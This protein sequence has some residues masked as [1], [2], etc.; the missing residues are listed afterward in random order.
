MRLVTTMQLIFSLYI[1]TLIIAGYLHK[2]GSQPLH[3]LMSTL[4]KKYGEIFSLQLGS[5]FTIILNS[6]DAIHEAL[7]KKAKVFAGRPDLASF[8]T[9]MHGATGISMC[10]YT[11]QYKKNRQMVV[12]AM[13]SLYTD[14]DR[15]DNLLKHEARKMIQLFEIKATSKEIFDPGHAFDK[16][17]PSIMVHVM[18]G[19]NSPYDDPDVVDLV[20]VNKRW[21]QS[22]GGGSNLADF[23][24]FLALFPNERLNAIQESCMMFYKFAFK[25]MEE[26]ETDKCEGIYGTIDRLYREQALNSG[27]GNEG[28]NQKD[29]FEIGRIVNDMLGGGFDTL[30]GTLSWAMLHLSQ[31]P[32]VVSKCRKEIEDVVGRE[33]IVGLEHVKEMPYSMAVV[34]EI[35]RVASVAPLGLPHKTSEE[36]KIGDLIIPQDSM[37]MANLWSINNQPDLWKNAKEFCPDNFLQEDG[38]LSLRSTR[39]LASFSFGVRRCP[40]EKFTKLQLFILLT[41]FL[42]NFDFDVAKPPQDMEPVGGITIQPKPYQIQ[43]TQHLQ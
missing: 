19:K 24:K 30:P 42:R 2:L 7:V 35:F 32:E 16:I 4:S 15:F 27:R 21:F 37:V 22:A 31:S 1:I 20:D 10:D 38:S 28:L 5:R 23:L 8:T 14:K 9:T 29:M 34:Y 40:G 43:I 33:D 3:I 25:K 13:H 12:K 39:N 36:V 11:E 18:F 26:F 6:K 17:V 41:N